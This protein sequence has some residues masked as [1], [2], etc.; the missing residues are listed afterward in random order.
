VVYTAYAF[1]LCV[2]ASMISPLANAAFLGSFESKAVERN[3]ID[4]TLCGRFEGLRS[5]RNE[6]RCLIS[7]FFADL[8]WIA[9]VETLPR[10]TVLDAF[11]TSESS[12]DFARDSCWGIASSNAAWSL[13][14]ASSP[15]FAEFD[16]CVATSASEVCISISSSSSANLASARLSRVSLSSSLFLFRLLGF[17][18]CLSSVSSMGD[19]GDEASSSAFELS[20]V[21]RSSS[22]SSLSL[23][24]SEFGWEATSSSAALFC[25]CSEWL[26]WRFFACIM[27]P[28]CAESVLQPLFS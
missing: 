28:A 23:F 14:P 9:S 13:A 18:S 25:V 7:C 22:R 4:S 19:A 17:V 12:P 16:D 20:L 1:V 24:G 27:G 21:E 2:V 15:E 5:G 3:R 26:C 6:E 8:D 11:S 10:K